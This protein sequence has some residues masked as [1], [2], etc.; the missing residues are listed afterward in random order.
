MANNVW[1]ALHCSTRPISEL[2]ILYCFW[3]DGQ[4]AMNWDIET[5]RKQQL[6]FWGIK[7]ASPA[8]NLRMIEI[9]EIGGDRVGQPPIIVPVAPTGSAS[10]WHFPKSNG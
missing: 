9:A 6:L 5:S 4:N 10:H 8:V 3:H 1:Q 2:S 7:P